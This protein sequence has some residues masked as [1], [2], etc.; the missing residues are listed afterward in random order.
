MAGNCGIWI[1]HADHFCALLPLEE[2]SS[3]KWRDCHA[4]WLKSIVAGYEMTS[5]VGIYEITDPE[6]EVSLMCDRALLALLTVKESYVSKV[7]WYD[8]NLRK[9]LVE[10]QKLTED[11]ERALMEQQFILYFQP[12]INYANGSVVGIE[13]LVLW[14]HPVWGLISPDEFIPLFEKN[15]FI[16]KLD[17]YVWEQ[18][19]RYLCKWRSRDGESLSPPISVNISR[20]DICN[21]DLCNT[22][23]A[24]MEQYSLSQSQLRLE[25]TESRSSY[26][27]AGQTGGC[28]Q[29]GASGTGGRKAPGRTQDGGR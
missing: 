11:M 1:Y 19:C 24:L 28:S 29:S 27:A 4:R 9:K 10:E 22:L 20:C 2:F 26:G 16:Q 5:S 13:A 8:D 14:Q 21:P 15:G 7:A 12:Q 25:I 18:S 23:C 17:V 6:I 3:P